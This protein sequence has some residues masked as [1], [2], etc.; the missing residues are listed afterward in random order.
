METQYV[1]CEVGTKFLNHCMQQLKQGI[2]CLLECLSFA[3]EM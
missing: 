1:F 2:A 3:M